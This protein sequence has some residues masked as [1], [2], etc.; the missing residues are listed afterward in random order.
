MKEV[1][2]DVYCY[3]YNENYEVSNLG[4]VRRKK[5]TVKYSNGK[6]VTHKER[7]LKGG[8]KSN[9]Y[10]SISMSHKGSVIDKKVSHLVYFTFNEVS[11]EPIKRGMVIDHIDSDPSNDCLSNLQMISQSENT[12]RSSIGKYKLPKHISITGGRYN[13]Q[14]SI[15]NKVHSF[16]RFESLSEAVCFRDLMIENNWTTE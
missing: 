13:V 12:R 4:R 9:K 5:R 7:I 15:S 10:R 16:G 1:W 14:K 11:D 3:P 8:S 6:K 2:K